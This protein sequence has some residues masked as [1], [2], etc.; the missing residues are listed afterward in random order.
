MPEYEY[1]QNK[2]TGEWRRR[3]LGSGGAF[4]ATTAPPVE[5]VAEAKPAPVQRPATLS[6][7][8]AGRKITRDASGSATVMDAPGTGGGMG[9]EGILRDPGAAIKSVAG[10]PK[11]QQLAMRYGRGLVPWGLMGTPAG[12]TPWGYEAPSV[13]PQEQRE[14]YDRELAKVEARLPED[15]RGTGLNLGTAAELY[16]AL[17]PFSVAQGVLTGLGGV[18]KAYQLGQAGNVVAKPA[19]PLI[20]KMFQRAG[21]GLGKGSYTAIPNILS[22]GAVGAAVAPAV[23]SV[24]DAERVDPAHAAKYG[25]IMGALLPRSGYPLIGLSS[26][27]TTIPPKL[28]ELGFPSAGPAAPAAYG[29]VSA[30]ITAAKEAAGIVKDTA[31]AMTPAKQRVD[32][33][34]DTVYGG[35]HMLSDTVEKADRAAAEARA[36]QVEPWMQKAAEPLVA[37]QTIPTTPMSQRP[38][39]VPLMLDNALERMGPQRLHDVYGLNQNSINTIN[40]IVRMLR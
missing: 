1:Q 30:D 18:G 11:F 6:D 27:K 31:A 23:A 17:R 9:I 35:R 36:A 22:R 32:K 13:S 29:P 21:G 10:N 26:G 19:I 37:A 39:A 5:A 7:V 12:T 20:G 33:Y 16:G 4:T 25:A 28:S 40:S 8:V 14:I 34:A 2:R 3:L 15:E 24:T 38:D